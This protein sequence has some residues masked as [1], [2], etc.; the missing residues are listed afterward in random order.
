LTANTGSPQR[1]QA[2]AAARQWNWQPIAAVRQWNWQP[3][4]AVR[5]WNWQPTAAARQWDW[6]PT[7]AALITSDFV[8]QV[9]GQNLSVITQ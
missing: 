8:P 5:Q 2:I 4:A 6:Q 3:T 9:Q 1:G 7:A